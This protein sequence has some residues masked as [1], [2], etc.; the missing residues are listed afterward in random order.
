M[1][2]QGR[3]WKISAFWTRPELPTYLSIR[4]QVDFQVAQRE[5][6]DF[7]DLPALPSLVL[8]FDR[9][10]T[11]SSRMPAPAVATTISSGFVDCMAA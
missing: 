4:L 10:R 7:S 11:A 3:M 2:P 9:L 5:V 8:A 1:G 6:L